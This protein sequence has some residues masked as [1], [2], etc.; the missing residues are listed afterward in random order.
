VHHAAHLEDG[1]QD[2][3]HDEADDGS[4]DHDQGRLQQRRKEL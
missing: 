2:S 4:D 3:H 1:Q